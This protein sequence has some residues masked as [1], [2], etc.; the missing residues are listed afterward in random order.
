MSD[1]VIITKANDKDSEWQWNGKKGRIVEVLEEEGT[2]AIY[3]S[4]PSIENILVFRK[5]EFEYEGKGSKN[6]KAPRTRQGLY[7]LI[8]SEVSREDIISVV[9]KLHKEGKIE[10]LKE[11]FSINA[12]TSFIKDSKNDKMAIVEFLRGFNRGDEAR[13]YLPAS[14]R[15]DSVPEKVGTSRTTKKKPYRKK[16]GPNKKKTKVNKKSSG[17]SQG[18]MVS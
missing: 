9:K 13:I 14:E 16:K 4:D 8:R 5:G 17:N 10:F 18:S 3:I 1:M 12:L 6:L 7:N 2:Y 15:N 11:G